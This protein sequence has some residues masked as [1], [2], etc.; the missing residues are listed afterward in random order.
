V[1]TERLTEAI[2]HL[3]TVRLIG[4]AYTEAAA[5]AIAQRESV[6]IIVLELCEGHHP[7]H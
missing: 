4:T 3:D 6:D 2:H 7:N 5:V 1:L